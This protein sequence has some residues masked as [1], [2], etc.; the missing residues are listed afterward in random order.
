[1]K[2]SPLVGLGKK[3]SSEAAS[4]RSRSRIQSREKFKSKMAE[5]N[6][7]E[8][9]SGSQEETI[10]VI[11]DVELYRISNGELDTT[12]MLESTDPDA[13]V[14]QKTS[15]F[16]VSDLNV[17]GRGYEAL[18]ERAVKKRRLAVI[19]PPIERRWEY[20]VYEEP[21]VIEILEKHDDGGLA[22]CF[23]QLDNGREELVSES[24]PLAASAAPSSL[25]KYTRIQY[26]PRTPQHYNTHQV[27]TIL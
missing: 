2:S 18:N 1:M 25:I 4:S 12:T 16:S 26:S 22:E 3:S 21:Q 17:L 13:A 8:D 7:Y 14:E 10:S 24:F 5:I 20:R 9:D 27:D 6:V 19:A 23:V 11:Q 15:P